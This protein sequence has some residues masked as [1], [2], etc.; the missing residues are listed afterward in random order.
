MGRIV[1]CYRVFPSS[2]FGD[3]TAKRLTEIDEDGMPLQAVWH[4]DTY[5]EFHMIFRAIVAK[6]AEGEKMRTKYDLDNGCQSYLYAAQ[7]IEDGE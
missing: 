2:E 6:E 1:T 5:D 7:T 4:T 3:W